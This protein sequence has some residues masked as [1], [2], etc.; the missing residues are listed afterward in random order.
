MLNRLQHSANITFICTGKPQNLCDSLYCH[1][2]FIVVARN[3]T[4]SISK[5]CLYYPLFNSGENRGSG[6]LTEKLKVTRLV[7]MKPGIKSRAWHSK[8]CLLSFTIWAVQRWGK[9]SCKAV[10][11]LSLQVFWQK[12]AGGCCTK[13]YVT[14][15]RNR[16][17][18]WISWGEA[19]KPETKG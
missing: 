4:R 6:S 13:D 3:W 9:V 1:I 5:V 2:R 8:P 7:I 15:W 11:C 18:S 16:L 12:P 10:C 14:K 17:E 19:K